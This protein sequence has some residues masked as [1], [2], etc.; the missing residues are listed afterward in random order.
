MSS[1]LS[2]RSD[3]RI[4]GEGKGGGGEA[5]G[6]DFFH[7]G[8]SQPPNQRGQNIPLTGLPCVFLKGDVQLLEFCVALT[9]LGMEPCHH[10]HELTTVVGSHCALWSPICG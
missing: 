3:L 7:M 4:C 9:G 10:T 5:Q 1:H 8:T 2:P 6:L